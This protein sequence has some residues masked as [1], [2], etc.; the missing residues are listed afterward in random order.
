MEAAAIA[1]PVL[2]GANQQLVVSEGLAVGANPEAVRTQVVKD[3]R[4]CHTGVEQ[5]AAAP[6]LAALLHRF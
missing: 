1:W 3:G 6:A 5:K 4:D 2:H